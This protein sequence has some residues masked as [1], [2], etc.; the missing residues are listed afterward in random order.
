M[1][2]EYSSVFNPQNA[3]EIKD[4]GHC[5]IEG[6]NDDGLYFYLVIVTVRG[7]STIAT[8][9]PVIPDITELPPGYTSELHNMKFNQTKIKAAVFKW[10]NSSKPG[11]SKP[12]SS[13]KIIC[14]EEALSQF[15][16]VGEYFYEDMDLSAKIFNKMEEDHNG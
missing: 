5:A 2:I 7:Y 3:L 14:I 6:V 15:R 8:C 13:A 1:L 12:I 9:G 11:K 4:I 16:N 10:L